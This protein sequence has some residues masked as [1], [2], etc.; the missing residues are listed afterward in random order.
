MKYQIERIE[1]IT[2]GEEAQKILAELFVFIGENY[3]QTA[4]LQDKP[5]QFFRLWGRQD[6]VNQ[7]KVMTARDDDGKVQGCVMA[8]VIINPLFIAKPYVIRFVELYGDDEKFKQ[9]VD[10]VLEGV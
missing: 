9:Y 3:E 8:L 7:I 2:K 6:P 10:V 4:K 5:F 1:E